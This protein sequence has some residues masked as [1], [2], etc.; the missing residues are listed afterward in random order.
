MTVHHCHHHQNFA[1]QEEDFLLL[2]AS[3][4]FSGHLFFVKLQQTV[5][6]ISSF[7]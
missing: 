5:V 4:I 7:V 1:D 6:C 3:R 2:Y